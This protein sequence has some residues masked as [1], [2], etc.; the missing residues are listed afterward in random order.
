MPSKLLSTL[1]RI[2]AERMHT[3]TILENKLYPVNK[4]SHYG[5]LNKYIENYNQT[6][7]I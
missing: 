1:W 3:A 2:D 5:E 4:K 7:Q 6:S